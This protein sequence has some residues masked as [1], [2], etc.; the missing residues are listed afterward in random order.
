MKKKN[1]IYTLILFGV[2]IVLTVYRPQNTV[3]SRKEILR[4]QK[5]EELKEKLDTGRKKLEE[6]I[7]RN[8]K[9]LEENEIK[10][11]EIRKK[12][13]NIKDEILSESDEKIRR[14]KLD[15]F[16]TEIDEY[17]YFPEDSVIILEALKES[18]SI[19]DIKKI[20]M[21]LYKS[22][23]SMNQFDKA[24]KIMAELKGGKNA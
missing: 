8:Q 6:T 18:L 24:D 22:Y 16:L 11:G 1:L 21:R 13:E 20:N 12:L 23:K 15:V 17:K 4:E 9:L 14:E 10:R 5:Q 7:Q 2:L 19:D 3:K